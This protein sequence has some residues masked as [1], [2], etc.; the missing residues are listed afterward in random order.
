MRNR[1]CVLIALISAQAVWAASVLTQHNDNARTGWN[2]NETMLTPATVNVS[3]FGKLFTRT[4]DAN[5]S[6][7]VLVANNITINKHPPQRDDRLHL[8]HRR[9]ATHQRLRF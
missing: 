5:V 9:R 8:K 6:G 3:T 2:P 7:Q 1:C 4:V